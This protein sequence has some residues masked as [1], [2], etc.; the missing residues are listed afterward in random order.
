MADV[1]YIT[2]P[3]CDEKFKSTSDKEGKKVRCPECDEPF[4]VEEDMITRPK[5]PKEPPKK[6]AKKSQETETG[7]KK[8]TPDPPPTK[9]T[10]APAAETKDFDPDFDQDDNPYAV[11]QV[12]VKPR[13]PNCAKE[14]ADEKAFI[15]LN[16]GYNS[17]TREIGKTE[18]TVAITFEEHLAHLA[19][20]LGSLAM[21]VFIVI[22]L[23]W[24]CICAPYQVPF[25]DAEALRMWVTIIALFN[26]FGFGSYGLNKVVFDPKPKEKEKETKE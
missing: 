25:L 15:C 8:M 4:R 11:E 23:L 24:L 26:V 2:C 3:E 21:A 5:K 18:K 6:P 20:A 19:G 9:P 10:P 14:M 16:C 7:I 13:C 22:F 17:L 12:D 1:I